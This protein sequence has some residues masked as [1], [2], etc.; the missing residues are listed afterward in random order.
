[1][2]DKIR[3]I[4]MGS[5]EF[6]VPILD[7]LIKDNF[8]IPIVY[9]QPDKPFGRTKKLKPTPVKSYALKHRL[10]I[11]DPENLSS[12]D[13]FEKI[14][15]IKPDIILVCS[16]G[17]IIPSSILDIPTY[18][19]INIH[20]SLLPKLRGSSPIQY[21]I[22][23]GLK[24][25][26]ITFIKM[27]EKIDHGPIL[28]QTKVPVYNNDNAASLHDRLAKSAVES[29]VKVLENVIDNKINPTIQNHS[30][31]TFTKKISRD[32]GLIDWSKSVDEISRSIRAYSP[33]PGSFTYISDGTSLKRLKIISASKSETSVIPPTKTPTFLEKNSNL[34]ISSPSGSLLLKRVQVAGKK[35]MPAIDFHKGY[36]H[37]KI[38]SKP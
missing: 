37:Y 22:L 10:S 33:W 30:L 3:I 20:A 5:S 34:Y 27:D 18:A 13:Q 36:N 11:A 4:Y 19:A 35:A 25:T 31:A 17:N 6:A 23:E 21:A 15:S 1:M 38:T 12:E 9:T 8:D 26:G 28:A 24:E 16:Y 14:K 32:D 2:S 29:V 7:K